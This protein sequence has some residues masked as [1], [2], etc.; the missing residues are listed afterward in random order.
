M[1]GLHARLGATAPCL[2][3]VNPYNSTMI[4]VTI[5]C[6]IHVFLAQHWEL[7]HIYFTKRDLLLDSKQKK[8]MIGHHTRFRENDDLPPWRGSAA[9]KK[10]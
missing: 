4:I 8:E 7:A 1:R 2:F 3:H 5:A 10:P 6:L 9:K